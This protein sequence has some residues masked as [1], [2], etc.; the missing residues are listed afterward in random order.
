MLYLHSLHARSSHDRGS[1]P[2]VVISSALCASP[3]IRGKEDSPSSPPSSD[4]SPHICKHIRELRLHLKRSQSSS[5]RL[6]MEQLY[7]IVEHLPRLRVLELRGIELYSTAQMNALPY[8]LDQLWIADLQIMGAVWDVLFILTS[9]G[10]R[11]LR[12]GQFYVKNPEQFLTESPG[13]P[14]LRL[15]TLTLSALSPQILHFVR[16][17]SVSVDSLRCVVEPNSVAALGAAITQI[18]H[19]VSRLE[20][21]IKYAG[22]AAQTDWGLLNLNQCSMLQTVVVYYGS[23]D[24]HWDLRMRVITTLPLSLQELVLEITG[25][26]DL[27]GL[28]C[29]KLEEELD[30]FKALK[31]VVFWMTS[32]TT[33][34]DTLPIMD[35]EPS[36]DRLSPE[37]L[38]KKLHFVLPKLYS[39]G[40]LVLQTDSSPSAPSDD[41]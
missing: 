16:R 14:Y 35:D 27:A 34:Y 25:Y 3:E 28:P 29:W 1:Q 13:A 2:R 19:T 31:K 7:F 21:E 41:K 24:T 18:R 11:D 12:M 22:F 23:P 20:F 37:D 9:S 39:R 38:R 33:T 8:H 36:P 6:S 10:V 32:R 15:R 40:L 4:D 17:A 5:S 26:E 30:K